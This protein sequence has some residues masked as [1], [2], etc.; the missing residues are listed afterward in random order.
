[1]GCGASTPRSMLY[2]RAPRRRPVRR[3]PTKAELLKERADVN[4]F[5]ASKAHHHGEH[6][7]ALEQLTLALKLDPKHKRARLTRAEVCLAL[8]KYD[9]ALEDASQAIALGHPDAYRVRGDVH[10]ARKRFRDALADLTIAVKVEPNDRRAWASRAA[11]HAGLGNDAKA[12]EDVAEAAKRE[13]AKED[14]GL[15]VVCIDEPRATRLN[16]CEHSA[17]CEACATECRETLGCCPICNTM[18]KAIEYGMFMN[19]FAPTNTAA[20]G[21]LASAIKRAR[22]ENAQM[23][24]LSRIGEGSPL[25]DESD[26]DG[27]ITESSEGGSLVGVGIGDANA[28]ARAAR[29][30]DAAAAGRGRRGRARGDAAAAPRLL[31]VHRRR[32][33]ARGERAVYA[34]SVERRSRRRGRERAERSARGDAGGDGGR[35][36]R[37]GRRGRGRG[38]GGG[39]RRGRADAV[40]WGGGDDHAAGDDARRGGVMR[41]K[42]TTDGRH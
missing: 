11:A 41:D 13:A 36:G 40:D 22:E 4:F 3:K 1:M 8:K 32:G 7:R 39:G 24:T 21:G 42:R 34:R 5:D 18:I 35:G 31:A 16:P 20:L 30:D 28:N 27:E 17:L 26:D 38:G 33:H 37:R 23:A 25:M 9:D 2:P 14:A 29:G 15:C 10:L 19:T 6:E 12:K